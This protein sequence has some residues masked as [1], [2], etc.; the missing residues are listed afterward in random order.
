MNIQIIPCCQKLNEVQCFG[1][2][3]MKFVLTTK[4]NAFKMHFNDKIKHAPMM[5]RP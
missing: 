4:F 1:K 2:V 3:N 5:N